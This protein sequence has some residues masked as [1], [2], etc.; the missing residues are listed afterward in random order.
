MTCSSDLLSRRECLHVNCV[1]Y[2]INITAPL[3]LYFYHICFGIFESPIWVVTQ[4]LE[5]IFLYIN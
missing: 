1:P 2:Y 4:N 5:Y 3:Q